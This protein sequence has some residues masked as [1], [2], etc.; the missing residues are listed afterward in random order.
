[1]QDLAVFAGGKHICEEEGVSFENIGEKP[2]DVEAFLGYAGQVTI[3]KDDTIFL[4][5]K[6]EKYYFIYT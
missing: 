4:N 2:E 5:G 1:M 3:T 6:G